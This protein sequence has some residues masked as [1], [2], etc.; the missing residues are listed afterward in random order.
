[1]GFAIAIMYNYNLAL[2]LASFQ[3][4]TH[5]LIDL[6]KGRMAGWFPKI[7]S[8]ENKIHWIVFGADQYLHQVVIILMVYF[9][10]V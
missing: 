3:L 6:W 10:C 7:Q 4:V 2:Q 1:M 8:P 9:A 5:F